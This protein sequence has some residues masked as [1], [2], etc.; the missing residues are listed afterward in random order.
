VIIDN[1]ALLA[2]LGAASRA[3]LEVHTYQD[4]THS[5]QFDAPDRLA[6]DMIAWLGRLMAGTRPE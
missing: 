6:R 1:P 3:R 5:I 4:Q 2:A